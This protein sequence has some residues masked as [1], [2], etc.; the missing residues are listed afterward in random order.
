VHVFY[1]DLHNTTLDLIK[2]REETKEK[3]GLERA[4]KEKHS[5]RL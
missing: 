2:K 1:T 5:D 4:K 3:L